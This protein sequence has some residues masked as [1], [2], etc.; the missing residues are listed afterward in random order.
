[1]SSVFSLVY[2]LVLFSQLISSTLHASTKNFNLYKLQTF[3]LVSIS[4][5][6]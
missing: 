2:H 4:K 3:Q 5:P 6:S 1:M